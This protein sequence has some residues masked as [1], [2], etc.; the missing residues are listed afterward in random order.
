MYYCEEIHLENLSDALLLTERG[1]ND[2]RLNL[3]WVFMETFGFS[4]G[5]G[6][7]GC[8]KE[9]NMWPPPISL[10]PF[11]RDST[12]VLTFPNFVSFPLLNMLLQKVNKHIPRPLWGS[13]WKEDWVASLCS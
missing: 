3:M 7:V 11:T 6:V 9:G 4:G 5:R 2:F 10:S 1:R 8:L 12:P 13:L